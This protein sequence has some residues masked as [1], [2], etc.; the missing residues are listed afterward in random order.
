MEE[1]ESLARAIHRLVAD[2]E[3]RGRLLAAPR[4]V[5]MAEL[6]VSGEVYDALVGLAPVLLAGSLVLLQGGTSPGSGGVSTEG[7][8][9]RWGYA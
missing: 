3:L 4:Q 8:W 7:T 1:K 5:L 6:G 9:G 2:K